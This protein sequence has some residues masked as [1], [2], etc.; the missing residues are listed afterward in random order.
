MDPFASFSSI[1]TSIILYN[2]FLILYPLPP[3]IF[4][5]FTRTTPFPTQ[6]VGFNLSHVPIH[7]SVPRRRSRTCCHYLLLT[8]VLLSQQ[9]TLHPLPQFVKPAPLPPSPHEYLH[10]PTVAIGPAFDTFDINPLPFVQMLHTFNLILPSDVIPTCSSSSNTIHEYLQATGPT[11]ALT[12]F[13][14]SFPLV[15]D[16]GASISITPVLSDFVNGLQ[17][18]PIPAVHGIQTSSPV[19]GAG[20]VHWKLQDITGNVQTIS[21]FELY[22]PTAHVRLFSPQHYFRNSKSG[23]VILDNT[24]TYFKCHDKS[25]PIE[26]PYHSDNGLPVIMKD[27]TSTPSLL[28][29]IFPFS[30]FNATIMH[31]DNSNLTAA[32]KELLHWHHRLGH[33]NMRW[34]QQ[35]LRT[36]NWIGSHFN[37]YGVEVTESSSFLPS[38]NPKVT[39]CPQSLCT[40]CVLA[41]SSRKSSRSRITSANANIPGL[42]TNHLFPGQVVSIDQYESTVR[43]R[44]PNTKG[45]EPDSEKF[46]GG[47]IGVDHASSFIFHRNQVSL[48]ASDTI[49][50]KR[51]WDRFAHSCG[52]SLRHFQCDNGV[53]RSDEFKQ[54]IQRANQSLSFSGVGA[55]HQNGVAER[56]IKTIMELARSMLLHA[57]LMWSDPINEGIW[58]FAVDH[59]IYLWNN[60]PN[61]DSGLTPNEIFRQVRLDTPR[62][63]NRLHVWGCPSYVLEP[64]L[65]D[66]KKI[67]KW[68]PRAGRG[69]FLGLSPYHSTSVGLV[70]NL[71]T[72]NI[73]PQYHVV[74]DDSFVTVSNV[75]NYIA[76]DLTSESP[77]WQ[78]LAKFHTENYLDELHPDDVGNPPPLHWYWLRRR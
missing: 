39:S 56:A 9:P 34:I 12:Q 53:F 16:S 6:P 73:S 69:Q 36:R 33:V 21:T 70:R 29:S 26:F 19:M 5:Q 60:L 22:L 44:L 51:I 31:S 49:T 48:R 13:P 47:T 20:Q 46:C 45:R 17:P 59:A 4:N 43:G 72:N 1:F 25:A 28:S 7:R 18:S 37:Q 65:Q 76:S 54:A 57:A 14:Q 41:K 32:Q 35:L 27:L 30:V 50:T 58:P 75:N 64:K 66:G 15:L 10:L 40:A 67:P 68:Q 61:V 62:H 42:K 74:Y 38:S 77:F 11:F 3:S 52:V 78:E 23:N 55:H 24:T 2:L 71:R 8:R 63:L